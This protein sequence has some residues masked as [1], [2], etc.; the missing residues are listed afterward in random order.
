MCSL[1][2]DL[3]PALLC[4]S[5][6]KGCRKEGHRGQDVRH[7]EQEQVQED[8]AVHRKLDQEHGEED[9]G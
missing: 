2:P 4:D 5:A 6:E 8:A 9:P 3:A 7:Q 1:I